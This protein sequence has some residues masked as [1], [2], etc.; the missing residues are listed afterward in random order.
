MKYVAITPQRYACTEGG[1]GGEGFGKETE[2]KDIGE[3]KE[4]K[5]GKVGRLTL[6]PYKIFITLGY[7][8]VVGAAAVE[9]RSCPALEKIRSGALCR[10]SG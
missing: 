9:A 1:G 6:Y 5:S 3:R 8:Q 10:L 4:R 7:F 2:R